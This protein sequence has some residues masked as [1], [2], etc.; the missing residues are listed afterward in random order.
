MNLKA[1]LFGGVCAI[2]LIG[3]AEA[4]T[5]PPG[6]LVEGDAG[7]GEPNGDIT[8]PTAQDSGFY[9]VSTANGVNGVGAL[10]GVGCK[11]RPTKGVR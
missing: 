11:G 4:A 9:Y 10:P 3:V 2:S 5:L 8:A 1:A 7:I 6:W